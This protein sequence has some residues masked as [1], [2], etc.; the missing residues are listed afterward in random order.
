MAFTAQTI[1][2]DA[3]AKQRIGNLNISLDSWTDN[4]IC[5]ITAGSWLTC[6]GTVYYLSGGDLTIDGDGTLAGGA[7]S[8]LY[9][10]HFDSVDLDVICTSSAP[11]W[12][13]DKAEWGQTLGGHYARCLGSIFKNSGGTYEQ[14]SIWYGRDF[15]ILSS[16]LTVAI[17]A[18]ADRTIRLASDCRILWDESEDEVSLDK[19]LN[20]GS[21]IYHGDFN[22]AQASGTLLVQQLGSGTTQ[23]YIKK[24]I[25][26]YVLR[27]L[28]GFFTFDI[29]Q[30]SGWRE[31]TNDLTI[32]A[33]SLAPGLYRINTTSGAGSGGAL[34]CTGVFS[35]NTITV[36]EIIL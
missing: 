11:T 8:T 24:P 3:L 25:S 6:A 13:D 34:Y 31:I 18:N 19:D 30:N 1:L 36:S 35:S 27:V 17:G 2:S 16:G 9:Y 5:N 10:Y 29:Y 26:A 21:N 32:Y 7:N 28:S 33:L 14:K 12:Q 20:I 15:G 23:F 22:Y 4:A